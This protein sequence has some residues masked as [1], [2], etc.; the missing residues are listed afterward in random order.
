MAKALYSLVIWF[1]VHYQFLIVH[2]DDATLD[3]LHQC[4]KIY[5]LCLHSLTEVNDYVTIHEYFFL[6]HV[7]SLRANYS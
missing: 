6:N 7:R 1:S 2:T 3:I 4:E 5:E